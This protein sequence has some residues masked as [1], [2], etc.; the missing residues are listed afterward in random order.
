MGTKVHELHW[1]TQS[2]VVPLPPGM[3]FRLLEYL[4]VVSPLVGSLA[5]RRMA[6]AVD[7]EWRICVLQPL[8]CAIDG[9][10][11]P[12]ARALGTRLFQPDRGALGKRVTRDRR[13]DGGC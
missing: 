8:L 10:G 9:H 6:V 11:G 2:A 12:S 13:G 3:V 7:R 5:R 4:V 1:P